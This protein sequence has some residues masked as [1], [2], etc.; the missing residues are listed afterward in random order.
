MTLAT[1]GHEYEVSFDVFPLSF[2]TAFHNIVHMTT[3][4]VC[5]DAPDRTP[6]I[7]FRPSGGTSTTRALHMASSVNG[8]QHQFNPTTLFPLF[9]WVN[10][11]F[12]QGWSTGVVYYEIFINE[13]RVHRTVNTKPA[14]YHNVKV[15]ASNPWDNP[16]EGF[17]SNLRVW[18][19]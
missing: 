3:G 4:K 18:T 12:K 6:A 19:K 5:C 10:V 17:I 7:W 15:Y 16:Q 9:Q 8:V 2:G 1:L 13:V 11:R 14:V